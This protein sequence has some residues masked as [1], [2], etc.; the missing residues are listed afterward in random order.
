MIF[1]KNKSE[2]ENMRK[3]GKILAKTMR[4]MS[5]SIVPGKTTPL[6]LDQ[7][8]KRI[9]EESGATPSFLGYIVSGKKYP[10]STC[11]SVNSVVVHGIPDNNPLQEGDIVGLDLG[12]FLDGWHADA[13]WTYP[14]GTISPNAQKLLNVTKESLYQ[15]ISQAKVH[16]Y[17]GDISF[18][19]QR[20]V[21]SHGFSIV[22]DLVG[23]GIGRHLHEEPS[24]PNFG[25]SKSGT[26]LKE[27][28]TLCIEPM[29]NEGTYKVKTLP[30]QWT[31]STEDG[32]LSAHF[33]HMIAITKDGPDIL[34]L[35]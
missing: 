14:V 4:L 11:I 3:S 27:G 28:M 1:L 34:T 24:I 30:D 25:K 35:E 16:S 8:A 7:L 13:A 9:I 22:R 29:V 31:L 2:I 21:E 12:V 33:E 18:A 20:Y 26:K 10:C 23:H 19:V 15:G 5:E 6:E 17:V 32:K